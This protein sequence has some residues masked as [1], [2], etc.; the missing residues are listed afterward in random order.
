MI[1]YCVRTPY[2]TILTDAHGKPI[3]CLGFS[4]DTDAA[5]TV[6]KTDGTTLACT[7]AGGVIHGLSLVVAVTGATNPRYWY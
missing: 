1:D 4:M 2:A 7:L 6:T 5:V 3:P